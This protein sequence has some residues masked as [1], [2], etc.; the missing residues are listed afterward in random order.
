M[1]GSGRADLDRRAGGQRR[2]GANG[3]SAG[4]NTRPPV[5]RS[6]GHGRLRLQCRAAGAI[7]QI[8]HAPPS[9]LTPFSGRGANRQH[10]PQPFRRQ[11]SRIHSIPSIR[12]CR[13]RRVLA[14]GV[15]QSIAEAVARRRQDA[16]PTISSCEECGF[17]SRRRRPCCWPRTSSILTLKPQ[18]LVIARTDRPSTA[19]PSHPAA[20]CRSRGR[21]SGEPAPSVRRRGQHQHLEGAAQ[22]SAPAIHGR[23]FFFGDRGAQNRR[24]ASAAA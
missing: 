9:R 4:A 15:R 19:R 7:A 3:P 13:R 20:P 2:Y 22:G 8:Q 6:H 10:T 12:G 11:R 18:W 24:P 17:C 1:A 23:G 16:P 5:R 21:L 14:A